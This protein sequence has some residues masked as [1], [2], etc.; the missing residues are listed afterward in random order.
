MDI[1]I[2]ETLL[3]HAISITAGTALLSILFYW[4]N[5]RQ[6]Y[7]LK[8]LLI[9]GTG[10]LIDVTT[11][12]TQLLDTTSAFTRLLITIA[13]VYVLYCALVRTLFAIPLTRA[14]AIGAMALL[15]SVTADIALVY[16]SQAGVF[17][18]IT[19]TVAPA[20]SLSH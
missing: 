14:L 20:V 12:G 2:T 13:L 17:D 9:I 3:L 19:S 11:S 7:V 4:H 10:T 6:Y 18:P 1:P 16:L 5:L 15:L 8:A